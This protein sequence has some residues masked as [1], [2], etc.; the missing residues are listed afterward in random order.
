MSEATTRPDPIGAAAALRPGAR[1]RVRLLGP[2]A[3][4][5]DSKLL[6]QKLGQLQP[7]TAVPPQE[8]TGQ[9]ASFWANLT[10]FSLPVDHD[11]PG[12]V[13]LRV[14]GRRLCHVLGVRRQEQGAPGSS[15]GRS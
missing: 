9:L 3:G 1:A 12:Y 6:A 10:A 15:R 8:S 4:G 5:N 2:D 13:R 14:G 11:V 7:S